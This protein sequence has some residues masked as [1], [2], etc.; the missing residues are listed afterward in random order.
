MWD[1]NKLELLAKLQLDKD[2]EILSAEELWAGYEALKQY[3]CTN[4]FPNIAKTEPSL[5]DHSEDHIQDVQR[6][7]F[8]IIDQRKDQFNAIEMFFLTYASLIHDIGN[9]FGRDGHEQ[10]AKDIIKDFPLINSSVKRI[11]ISIAK[12]HGGK[13]DPIKN[14]ASDIPYNNLPVKSREIAS[15]VRFADECAEGEQRCYSFGFEKGLISDSVSVTHHM[16]SKVTNVYIDTTA[17]KLNYHIA[18]DDFNSS[19]ELEDFLTFMFSRINKTNKERIYCAQYSEII[20]KYS[21]ID[22]S[23]EL[24]IDSLE[25]PFEKITFSLN[26]M[27]MLNCTSN[28]AESEKRIQEILTIKTIIQ[29]YGSEESN[30]TD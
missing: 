24:A 29:Y 22:V 2:T 1:N 26:N 17:I 9:I 23:I 25:E 12:A 30:G 13:G 7:I 21:S 8:K 18:L 14:L 15:I 28:P 27:S 4:I 16:Y 19:K 3:L 20:S 10:K 5:T 11:S 6:N